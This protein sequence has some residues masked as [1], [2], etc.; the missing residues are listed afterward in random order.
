MQK[1]AKRS[2]PVKVLVANPKTK[3]I[4]EAWYNPNKPHGFICCAGVGM[5]QLATKFSLDIALLQT[6]AALNGYYSLILKPTGFFN[7]LTFNGKR[8]NGPLLVAGMDANGN[9]QNVTLLPS[10]LQKLI[11]W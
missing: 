10:Q 5:G 9:N 1:K 11:T 7:S 8:I 3:K 4:T 2:K 6:D